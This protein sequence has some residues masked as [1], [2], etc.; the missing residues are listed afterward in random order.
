M[1]SCIPVPG[2]FRLWVSREHGPHESPPF[3]FQGEK[4]T[5]T[6]AR[7]VFAN[8]MQQA[9]TGALSQRD[10]AK[11]SQA[12]QLLRRAKRPAMNPRLHWTENQRWKERK[13]GEIVTAEEL[14]KRYGDYLRI[15]RIS[16]IDRPKDFSVVMDD[17]SVWSRTT[18][19]MNPTN[20]QMI[21]VV[22]ADDRGKPYAAMWKAS[23]TEKDI[24][25]AGQYAREQNGKV[26]VFPTRKDLAA[27]KKE[28]IRDF[29]SSYPRGAEYTNP[30]RST[31]TI[32]QRVAVELHRKFGYSKK[33]AQ[34]RAA[35]TQGSN[36]SEIV[37][38]IVRSDT[39][40]SV[41]GLR[42]PRRS[43]QR[44]GRALEIRYKREIGRQPGYY[45][46]EIESQ[47]AGLY[48]ISE[49]WIYVPGK[50]ILITE[51]KPRV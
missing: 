35:N 12:R 6:E 24:L 47:R 31:K 26:F 19:R 45:K 30:R 7:R 3:V 43:L 41:G 14:L 9:R 21:L 34:E 4:L 28:A 37:R 50:S 29:L 36:V 23:G 20:R 1:G 44:L 11:L 10:K 17:G 25:K 15:H 13:T 22:W 40:R 33:E 38:R 27:A 32:E 16:L 5:V 51:G 18:D 42:N 8:L 48:T 49:G 2:G 39:H 46:H